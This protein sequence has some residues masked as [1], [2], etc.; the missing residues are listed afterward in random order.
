MTYLAKVMIKFI[1]F[2]LHCIQLQF[3]KRRSVYPII[4]NIIHLIQLLL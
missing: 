2:L 4:I 1:R 3:V